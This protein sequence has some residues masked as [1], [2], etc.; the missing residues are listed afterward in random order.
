MDP[1][2]ASDLTLA[3]VAGGFA[4]FGV[5]A[6]IAYD[7]VIAR[8]A[9]K[10]DGLERYSE[11][12]KAAYEAFL[13]AA[14]RQLVA[15]KALWKLVGEAQA[16]RTD[17]SLEEQAAVPPSAMKDLVDALDQIRRLARVYSVIASAEAIVQLYGDMAG[18]SRTALTRPGPNDEIMWF[19]LQRFL[20]ERTAEFVH[21]YREDLGLGQPVGAPRRWP[22]VKLKRRPVSLPDSER[23]LRAQIPPPPRRRSA[24]DQAAAYIKARANST[25]RRTVSRKPNRWR[26]PSGYRPM[27]GPPIV[28]PEA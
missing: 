20:E 26:T 7:A 10:K 27:A 21:G 2:Q 11:E 6:K 22:I 28:S 12:R 18:V 24:V 14:K 25:T 19:L 13:D 5:L 3:L 15:D 23:I 8:R 1:Q 4:S 16:G 9:A 17:I